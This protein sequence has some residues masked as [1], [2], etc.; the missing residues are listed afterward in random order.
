MDIYFCHLLSGHDQPHLR[1]MSLETCGKVV[2][3]PG[4][5]SLS[6]HAMGKLGGVLLLLLRLVPCQTQVR[7]EHSESHL[8]YSFPTFQLHSFHF[9]PFLYDSVF[10]CRTP[11]LLA[12]W[13]EWPIFRS[14]RS[15]SG[16]QGSIPSF[17]DEIAWGIVRWDLLNWT[18]FLK[19]TA[20]SGGLEQNSCFDHVDWRR[21]SW[22]RSWPF[23]HV[24]AN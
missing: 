18:S 8:F 12:F 19:A 22:C 15:L 3:I 1:K 20:A 9:F 23:H 24:C 5:W 6:S 11:Q 10:F 2:L 7:V 14:C 16:F 17:R 21:W 13:R 4:G